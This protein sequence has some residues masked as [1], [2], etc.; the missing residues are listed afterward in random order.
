MDEDQLRTKSLSLLFKQE[1]DKNCELAS[2]VEGMLVTP[3]FEQGRSMTNAELVTYIEDD[4]E[5]DS[6]E[7]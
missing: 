5:E 3:P 6:K 7:E 4:E 1:I 2:S